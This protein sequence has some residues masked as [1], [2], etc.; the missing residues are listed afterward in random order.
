MAF[1]LSLTLV[2]QSK[3]PRAAFHLLPT[4]STNAIP[5]QKK[6]FVVAL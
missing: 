2:R 6:Y 3:W 1:H 5:F 4:I